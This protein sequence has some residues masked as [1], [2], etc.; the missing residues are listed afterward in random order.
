MAT[1]L[2]KLPAASPVVSI[3]IPASLK[4]E[5][6]RQFTLNIIRLCVKPTLNWKTCVFLSS[7]Q[8]ESEQEC[9]FTLT[10]LMLYGTTEVSVVSVGRVRQSNAIVFTLAAMKQSL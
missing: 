10:S 8:T 4:Q 3:N 9:R 1:A 7:F 5:V 2:I 6:L